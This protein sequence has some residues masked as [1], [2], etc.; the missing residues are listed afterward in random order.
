MFFALLIPLLMAAALFA[1][2]LRTTLYRTRYTL[3][4]VILFVRKVEVFEM[5]RLL[6]PA[7]EWA[8][9]TLCTKKEFREKQLERMRLAFEYLKRMGHN[10][11]VIQIWATA[12]QEG[13][14]RKAREDY[15]IQDMLTC[16]L[17]EIAT[18]LRICHLGA[19]IKVA[20][21]LFLR[22]HL[23]PVR[24]VPRIPGLRVVCEQDIV[25]KYRALID[26]STSLSRMYGEQY[27]EQLSAAL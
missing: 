13:L 22:C 9:R 23:W 12:L 2:L 6:D 11:E 17:V 7:E 26:I 18:E 4:D 20:S 27:Y 3:P 21:W 25:K 16:E 5:A 19:W 10:A 24:F 14:R 1:L 15:T 8:L